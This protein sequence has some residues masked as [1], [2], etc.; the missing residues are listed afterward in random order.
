MSNN[1]DDVDDT[2]CNDVK[3]V[4]IRSESSEDDKEIDE[5]FKVLENGTHEFK[6][7]NGERKKHNN[8]TVDKKTEKKGFWQNYV[9]AVHAHLDDLKKEAEVSYTRFLESI[10]TYI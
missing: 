7:E 1:D 5:K 10:T 9:S 8:V 3:N 2:L 4:E 6:Q